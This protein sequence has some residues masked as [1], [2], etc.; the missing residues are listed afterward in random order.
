VTLADGREA[1][2]TVHNISEYTP[3]S[4]TPCGNV[5]CSICRWV[6]NAVTY[7]NYDSFKSRCIIDLVPT[8]TSEQIDSP[9]MRGLY[10]AGLTRYPSAVTYTTY[11]LTDR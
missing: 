9:C 11:D 10:Q 1:R 5:E 4:D 2:K 6:A 7:K 8:L 3:P